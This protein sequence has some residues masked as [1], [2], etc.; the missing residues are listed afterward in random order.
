MCLCFQVVKHRIAKMFVCSD[1]TRPNKLCWNE[2]L[3]LTPG[4]SEELQ[5]AWQTL[6][7]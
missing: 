7:V 5:R 3:R 6:V 4:T 1:A 2:P